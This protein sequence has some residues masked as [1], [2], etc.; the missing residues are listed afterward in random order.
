MLRWRFSSGIILGLVLGIPFGAILSTILAPPP[1]A[2]AR[3]QFEV[4]ELTR[5]LEA[6]NEARA[7]A[8]KQL[9]EFTKLADQ[10]TKSF[11]KLEQR[12]RELEAEVASAKIQEASPTGAVL[13]APTATLDTQD[14]EP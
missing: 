13:S 5:Q 11:E 4:R 2:D 12:F 8:E 1:Q 6:A 10:M 14:H 9:E 3:L 7:R